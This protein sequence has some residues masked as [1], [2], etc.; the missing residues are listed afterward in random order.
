MKP[1]DM[2]RLGAEQAIF[3]KFKNLT[4]ARIACEKYCE[5]YG[6]SITWNHHTLSQYINNS[7]N[8]STKRLRVLAQVLGVTNYSELD[9]V[10][11][12][13]SVRG[14]GRYWE[15]EFGNRVKDFDIDLR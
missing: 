11:I 9:E 1:S 12:A 8:L 4:E 15:G 6:L 10:F 2:K 13:P 3:R 5:R 7:T 14:I